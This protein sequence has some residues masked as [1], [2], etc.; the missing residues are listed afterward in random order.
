MSAV[1]DTRVRKNV[2]AHLMSVLTTIKCTYGAFLLICDRLPQLV[3]QTILLLL[4]KLDC[5]HGRALWSW[6]LQFLEVVLWDEI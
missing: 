2:K 3:N 1:G 6:P 5:F 4:R